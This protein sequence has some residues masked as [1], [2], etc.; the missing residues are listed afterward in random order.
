MVEDVDVDSL[1][2][3][4]SNH[5]IDDLVQDR[6]AKFS[7][8]LSHLF[9]ENSDRINLMALGTAAA[10]AKKGPRKRCMSLP[11]K[12]AAQPNISPMSLKSSS[13]GFDSEGWPRFSSMNNI[14]TTTRFPANFK[15]P[16]QCTK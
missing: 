2:S 10:A 6:P 12:T 5:D 11:G 8:R 4:D 14:N 16:Q 1:F 13:S 3:L 15:L 9:E 7:S